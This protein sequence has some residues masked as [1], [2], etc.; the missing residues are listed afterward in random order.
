M[1]R[2]ME[3][4]CGNMMR[5][6]AVLT[7]LLALLAPLTLATV[8]LLQTAG[9]GPLTSVPHSVSTHS[10]TELFDLACHRIPLHS[11]TVAIGTPLAWWL[12]HHD[13]HAHGVF[14]A[15]LTLPFLMPTVVCVVGFLTLMGP[16]GPLVHLGIDLRRGTGAIGRASHMVG[17]EDLGLWIAL[18]TAHAW[19]NIAL[20]IRFLDP[21]LRR[22]TMRCWT[23][24]EC[25][26]A[27]GHAWVGFAISGFRCVGRPSSQ[28]RR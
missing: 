15:T 7:Y 11:P 9:N 6:I 20:V 12:G 25:S 19:F 17:I 4:C 10:G 13:G 24:S 28:E 3:R 27:L 21:L 16:E 1:D 22:W 2:G 14:R 8:R 5:R 26:L 23:S 18:L